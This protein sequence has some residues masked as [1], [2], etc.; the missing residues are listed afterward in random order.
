MIS[1]KI[2]LLL[3]ALVIL[4]AC[5]NTSP[6]SGITESKNNLSTQKSDQKTGTNI[7]DV[8]PEISLESPDG[9]IIKLSDL[10]GK[11]VLIDFWA[12]WCGPCRRENPNVV[13]AYDKYH[14]AKFKN[15]KGFEVYS[16]SLDRSAGPW[17]SAI[18][19]DNLTWPY[20]VSDLKFW[21]SAAAKEY[22]VQAIPTNFLIDKDGVIVAKNL[23]GQRLHTELD[24]HIKKL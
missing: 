11:M 23:R 3:S 13:A 14:K 20:H 5:A 24:K 12:S 4:V 19:Q 8:A 16:V 10:R 17:K 2:T 18:Q 9:E 6:E 7:G 1:K 15:A 21:S 22:G